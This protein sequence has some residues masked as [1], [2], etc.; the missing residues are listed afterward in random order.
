MAASGWTH[1]TYPATASYV[2]RTQMS[3]C[4]DQVIPLLLLTL[5]IWWHKISNC[6]S[7][8]VNCLPFALHI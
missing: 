8:F 5:N 6:W 3:G 7:A 1:P 2:L 4:N